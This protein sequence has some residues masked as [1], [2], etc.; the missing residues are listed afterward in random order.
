MEK[1]LEQYHGNQEQDKAVLSLYSYSIL[2][3]EAALEQ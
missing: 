3:P 2:L 1:T